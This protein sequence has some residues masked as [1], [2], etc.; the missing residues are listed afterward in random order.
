MKRKISIDAVTRAVDEFLAKK[1]LSVKTIASRHNVSATAIYSRLAKR[2]IKV[3]PKKVPLRQSYVF[4]KIAL[5]RSD[6]GPV[7][8]S[9]T[10]YLRDDENHSKVKRSNATPERLRRRASNDKYFRRKFTAAFREAQDMVR[11]KNIEWSASK[12]CR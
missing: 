12:I 10:E 5:R 3:T 8:Q 6:L 2:G 11:D 1:V 9:K 4:N 7:A